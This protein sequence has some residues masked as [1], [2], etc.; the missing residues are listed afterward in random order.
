MRTSR[1]PRAGPLF[2]LLLIHATAPWLSLVI[3]APVPQDD[4]LTN[5]VKDGLTADGAKANV[6]SATDSTID[7]A[8]CM[9]L[10]TANLVAPWTYV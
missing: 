2:I 8:S 10:P 4:S 1:M 5:K 6:D 9:G 3:A 7:A